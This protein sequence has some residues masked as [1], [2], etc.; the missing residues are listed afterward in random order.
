M[1]KLEVGYTLTQFCEDLLK[2]RFPGDAIRQQINDNDAEKLNFA[3][4][5]CGDSKTDPN[6]KRGHFY[7]NTN[8]YKCYNDG[9]SVLVSANKFISYFAKK[10]SLALP[11]LEQKVELKPVTTSKRK[12]SIIEFLINQEVG[13]KLLIFK[14]LV[15]RFSLSPCS[16]ADSQSPI[17]KYIKSRQLNRLPV[18]EQSCYYDS[19]QDKL[20]LFNLD[21][22]SGRVLGFAI[23]RIS[24]EWTGPKYDIKT[25]SELQKNGLIR[26][27]DDEFIQRV[28]SINNYFNILN[29]DFTKPVTITEGQID[30]MFVRNCIA[31]TGVSKGKQILDNLLVKNNTRILF[32]ND[33]AGRGASIDL[34]KKGYSVFLWANVISDLRKKYPADSKAIRNEIKD[35]NDLFKYLSTKDPALNFDSFNGFIDNYFSNSVFDLLSV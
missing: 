25:Y 10:Y 29:I 33:D 3:C 7:L 31:T 5:Y 14:D 23:R 17:G 4:P 18:F 34:L 15:N 11:S 24:S 27:L 9:C 1:F 22:K 20:Y 32:D 35:I 21:I 8:N 28:N 6:K 19:R 2:K 26:D 16:C 30:A 12:G 13:K